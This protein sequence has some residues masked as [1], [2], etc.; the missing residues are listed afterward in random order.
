[1]FEYHL[2]KRALIESRNPE[3]SYFT[4]IKPEVFFRFHEFVS[5]FHEDETEYRAVFSSFCGNADAI[6]NS[7]LRSPNHRLHF[8]DRDSRSSVFP[9]RCGASIFDGGASSGVGSTSGK[10]VGS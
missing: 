5:L 3:C 1:M 7:T 6:L 9:E 8:G 4:F 2:Q 10:E